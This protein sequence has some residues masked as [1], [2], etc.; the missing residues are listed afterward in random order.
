MSYKHLE[1]LMNKYNKKQ[2]TFT[3][4]LP[5]EDFKLRFKLF[6]WII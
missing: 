2:V 1:K 3:N 5:F 6:N 4:L